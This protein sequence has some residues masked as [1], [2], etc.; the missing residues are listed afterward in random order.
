MRK[1]KLF[2]TA[3]FVI[4]L[5]GGIMLW[6]TSRPMQMVELKNPDDWLTDLPT[7]LAKA[8]AEHKN[9]LMDFTGSDWCPPCNALRKVV[10]NTPEFDA[11]AKTNFVLLVVDFPQIKQ[12]PPEQAKANAD[13]AKKYGVDGFPTTIV[14]DGDAKVLIAIKGYK[15]ENVNEFLSQLKPAAT[16]QPAAAIPQTK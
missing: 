3:C 14:L 11:Y 7:A 16:N 2:A 6:S 8:K 1:L 10:F 5:I 4:A 13:L 9:V 15:G 12:L